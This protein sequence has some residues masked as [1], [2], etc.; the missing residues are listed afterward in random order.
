[1]TVQ[2]FI[3]AIAISFALALPLR[4]AEVAAQRSEHGATVEIDGHPFTEYIIQ[5]G[6]KPI[7]WPILG[8][9]GKRLTRDYPMEKGTKETKDHLHHRSLWFTHGNVNGIDFWSEPP[10]GKTG[11]IVHR[12]F[13]K[14]ESGTQAEIVTANDWLGPSGKKVL[15]D[16]RR[17]IF[18]TRGDARWID[19][20]ITLRASQGPVTFGDTKEGTFG[21]RVAESLRVDSKQGGQIVNSAGQTDAAAWGKRADWVDYHGPLGGETVGIAI[22]NHPSSFRYPTAWHVRTYG[23]FAANPFAERSFAGK[24]GEAVSCLLPQGEEIVLRYRV[25]LHRGDEKDGKVTEAFADYAKLKK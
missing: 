20:D 16:Q 25:F 3:P 19:F 9:T 7:L 4:A 23:L 1:M 8:P 10:T 6:T 18:G 24:G 14:I 17:L 22:F 2:R 11:T 15:E 5:S 21:L 12:K 13:V